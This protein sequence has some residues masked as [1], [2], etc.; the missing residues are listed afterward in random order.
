MSS[1]NK[2]EK[3]EL[4]DMVDKINTEFEKE[5]GEASIKYGLVSGVIKCDAISTRCLALDAAT[6]VGGFP[7]GRVIEIFGPE[8]SGKTTL[9]MTAIAEAQSKGLVA[10]MIDAEHA[11]DIAYTEALGVNLDELLFTQP[12]SGEHALQVCERLIESNKVGIIVID[13]VA[14]LVP[15][16]ELDG[17]I[18]DAI[19]GAQGRLMSQACRKLVRLVHKSKT[20][21]IFINQLRDKIGMLFP[22][23]SPDITPG[24]RALKFYASMRCDI[25]RIGGVTEGSGDNVEKTGNRVKVKIVKNKVAPPFREAEFQIMFGKGISTSGSILDVGLETG[26]I[27]KNGA[28]INYGSI[29]LGLGH[30]AAISFLDENLETRNEIE[31]KLRDI[32]LPKPTLEDEEPKDETGSE[33]K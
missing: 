23:S 8:A 28:S 11:V 1:K 13:S 7:R 14:A 24:G 31:A 27:K 9:A 12:D 18:G 21:L 4:G 6:G 19:I 5:H 16:K 10:A 3:N 29:R 33:E 22:G 17:E 30:Q 20:C 32:V 26:V 15:Q 25:R 2:K